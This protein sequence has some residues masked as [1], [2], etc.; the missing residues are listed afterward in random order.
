[1]PV[2]CEACLKVLTEEHP[3]NHA[4]MS[5]A[6]AAPVV[7]DEKHAEMDGILSRVH[8]DLEFRSRLGLAH[9]LKRVLSWFRFHGPNF[10]VLPERALKPAPVATNDCYA[11]AKD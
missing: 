7:T 8:K 4:G 10:P 2:K 11:W 1:M 6:G 5:S 3:T 9:N